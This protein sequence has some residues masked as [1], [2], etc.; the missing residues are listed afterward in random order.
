MRNNILW[1]LTGLLA[2]GVLHAQTVTGVVR[3]SKGETLP[4]ASVLA[5]GG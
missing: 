2:G 1:T 4:S 3:E 5:D